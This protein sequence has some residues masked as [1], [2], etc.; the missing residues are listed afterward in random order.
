MKTLLPLF[1][2]CL[3]AALA[4]FCSLGAARA[5]SPPLPGLSGSLPESGATYPA[6]AVVFLYG[7]QLALDDAEVTVDGA[8]AALVADTSVTAPIGALA[9]RV[10]PEPAPGQVVTLTGT[11]CSAGSGCPEETVT[12][13]AGPADD[14]APASPGRVTFDVYDHADFVA[15]IGACESD[16]HVAWFV[17]FQGAPP[18]E[19][20]AAPVLHLVE[21]FRDEKLSDLAFS[22]HAFA[23]EDDVTVTIRSRVETLE[24]AD[25]TEAICFRVTTIDTAGNK[26]DPTTLCRPCHF[27]AEPGTTSE[28]PL[29]PEWSD[30]D[31][32]AGGPCAGQGATSATS[33]GGD[34]GGDDPDSSGGCSC[35]SAPAPAAFVG[36]ALLG[37]AAA[38]ASRR[39]RRPG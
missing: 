35:R 26:A 9:V 14:D 5:C 17:H 37:F 22:S 3:S 30:A 18:A 10:D 8:P 38:L 31:A 24:G 25:V 36:P 11:F 28:T 20:G 23:S 7:Y 6:N 13:T 32:F 16:S 33:S 21:G 34:D 15:D 2:G 4:S 27:R 29:E 39:R 19:G 1:A 12:Y